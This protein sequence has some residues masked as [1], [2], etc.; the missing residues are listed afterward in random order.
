MR[1]NIGDWIERGI[2]AVIFGLILV[3]QERMQTYVAEVQN[4]VNEVKLS[5]ARMEGQFSSVCQ[6]LQ[7]LNDKGSQ[8][9]QRTETIVNMLNVTLS[10]ME[11]KMEHLEQAINA[12]IALGQK[13]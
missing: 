1:T 6:T 3:Q 12:H 4:R 9:A 13:P 5:N 7:L 2:I 8:T 10:K 11:S